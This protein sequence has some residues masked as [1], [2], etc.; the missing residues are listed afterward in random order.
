MY[1]AEVNRSF[2]S[3]ETLPPAIRKHFSESRDRISARTILPWGEHCT[4]CVWPTCYTTC[5]LYS[6][7]EDGA[8]RQ[9]VEGMVRLDHK[10]GL[11]PY[12]L[13]IKF[14]QWGKLWSVGNTRLL[15]LGKAKRQE[16]V[17]ITI[18]AIGRNLPLPSS[19][20]PR[21]LT[22][23]N[24]LRRQSTENAIGGPEIPD[25]FLLE[26]Y[27]PNSRALGLTFTVRPAFQSGTRAFQTM[28]EVSPG[29]TRAKVPFSQISKSVEIHQP[30]EV[31]IVPNDCADTVLYFGLL[32]FVKEQAQNAN[33]NRQDT[34][35]AQ[36]KCIVW[37]LDKTLWNGVL[38]EDGPDNIRLREGIVDVIGELDQ[39]GILQSIASK[40]NHDDA[41][42]VLRRY[43]LDQYF[44]YPQIH[45][46]PKSK[47]LAQI[48]QL[49]NIGV[50][51]LA[52]VDDQQF[53]REEV[54]TSLP[55]VTT[56]DAADYLQIP[57]RPE[58]QVPVTSE[59]KNRRLMYREQ[60]Q[61]QTALESYN[62]NY[63]E[64]L[65]DCGIELDVR[66]LDITNLKRVY[67]LA[68]RTNQLNFSGNHYQEAQ[69][70]EIMENP[71]LETYV[72]ECV[73]RFG[74]YGIVG[75]GL[76]D[77]REPRLLDL[78]FSCCI[79]SKRVE[80]AVLSFLIGRFVLGHEQDFYANYRKTKKNAPGGKVFEELGFELACEEAGVSS[81]VFKCGREILDDQI[82]R[83]IYH[84]RNGEG[85]QDSA[86]RG[87]AR[88]S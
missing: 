55:Q 30:F 33:T 88:S 54:R 75:F 68:Q 11:N 18:G 16:L 51:T 72:I 42:K 53:E 26:C 32:D 5:E 63:I 60:E 2:E 38:V 22:K 74:K 84:G 59:S 81:L 41:M 20:K 40:N 39:R 56:I 76:V 52:F 4:E 46:Q 10:D 8:C 58:C 19:I 13:K 15:P 47:S 1:E 44:L 86:V 27:N 34:K 9:F 57:A 25:Y 17:N 14:K 87:S 3:I 80:H 35:A 36:F 7:R 78:M 73:D 48:A 6:P 67:E 83:I 62:G 23:I 85:S 29:Y 61:R 24:Y 82:V 69:L 43:G 12:L 71:F 49:L 31:E 79:Q 37:D 28:I 65:R 66:S 64:F 70:F 21:V 50:D 77:T 45:W